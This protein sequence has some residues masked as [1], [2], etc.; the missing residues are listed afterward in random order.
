VLASDL[1]AFRRVLDGSGVLFGTGDAA[2]LATALDRWL[3]D[4]P[5]R[6][7]LAR[8]SA[9][10]VA[11]YDWPVVARRVLEVYASAIEATGGTVVD[12]QLGDRP[13]LL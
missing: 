5:G 13:P 2:A 4:A 7:E 1:D 6:A 12:E 8:R 10:V 9:E 3:D 11:A